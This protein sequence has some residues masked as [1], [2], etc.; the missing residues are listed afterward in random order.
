MTSKHAVLLFHDDHVGIAISTEDVM[1][2]VVDTVQAQEPFPINGDARLRA[3]AIGTLIAL[4][5]KH[6]ATSIEIIND[7]Q[8]DVEIIVD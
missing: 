2:R 1:G 7:S 8:E 5:V 4:A 3:Q 6:G